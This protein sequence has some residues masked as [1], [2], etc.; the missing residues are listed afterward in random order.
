MFHVDPETLRRYPIV[1]VL[2]GGTAAVFIGWLAWSAQ[3]ETRALLAQKSPA[4]VSIH[5]ALHASS[6][7][8]VT[9]AEGRWQCERT[10][11][12]KR[13]GL[14]QW[15][16]GKIENTEV[17]IHGPIDGEVL[18]A[19]FDGAA[20]CAERSGA[21]LTGVVGSREI[22]ASRGA[23]RRWSRSGHRVAILHVGADP[24]RALFMQIAVS[25]IALLGA[26]FAL[27]YLR[28]MLRARDPEPGYR[29]AADPIQPR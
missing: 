29:P 6:P 26:G 19:E 12:V 4:P 18:V 17:P 11:V 23:V 20:N 7:R 21:P 25:A 15:V 22:F 10:H 13:T 28:L 27:Y 5:E 8:W 1:G 3:D 24:R 9:I 16:F 14:E 2:I